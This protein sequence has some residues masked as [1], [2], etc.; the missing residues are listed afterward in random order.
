MNKNISKFKNI[1]PAFQKVVEANENE[2]KEAVEVFLSEFHDYTGEQSALEALY[3]AIKEKAENPDSQL[4]SEKLIIAINEYKSVETGNYLKN[5]VRSEDRK[6]AT[7]I[8]NALIKENDAKSIADKMV[9][10]LAV[11]AYFRSLHSASI[12]NSLIDQNG[13]VSMSTERTGMLKELNK[14]IEMATRQF[15]TLISFLKQSNRPP[16]NVKIKSGNAFIGENQQFNK[17]A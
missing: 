14:Q 17:N 2:V 6:H 5:S 7:C 4:H 8:R 1:N 15:T 13:N 3:K 9:I 10:D 12:Y 16:I 11:G